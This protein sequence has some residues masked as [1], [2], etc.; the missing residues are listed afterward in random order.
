MPRLLSG[1]LL[2]VSSRNKSAPPPV[3]SI[4][5]GIFGGTQMKRC[6]AERRGEPEAFHQA[7]D[8]DIV[9]VLSDRA[10]ENIETRQLLV[11]CVGMAGLIAADALVWIY[12][13]VI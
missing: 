3:L 8:S 13:W 1:A 5:C 11:L 2:A 9:V 6:E 10:H 12:F 7:S 4:G